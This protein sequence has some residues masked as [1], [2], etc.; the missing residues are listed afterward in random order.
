MPGI[1]FRCPASVFQVITSDHPKGRS[2][3]LRKMP[4]FKSVTAGPLTEATIAAM[5]S[6]PLD[7]VILGQGLAGTALAW[8]AHWAGLRFVV[9]DR[10][11]TVTSSKIAAGLMTPITGQRLRKSWRWSELWP[12]A[13]EYYRR[14]EKLTDRRFLRVTSMVRTLANLDEKKLFLERMREDDTR[15]HVRQP[16]HPELDPAVFEQTF[17]SFEMYDGGQ[18]NSAEYLT[19]S[20]EYFDRHDSVLT[21]DVDLECD[22]EL[23]KSGV[24]LPRWNLRAKRVVFCQGYAGFDNPWF[25]SVRFFAAKGE[26]LTV[27][28][29]GFTENRVIHGGL[30]LAPLGNERFRVGATYDWSRFD[31]VP[32][33]DGRNEIETRLRA[34]LRVPYTVEEHHAAVRPILSEPIPRLGFHPRWPQLGYFNG[35]ASKGALFAPYLS[36][37][38]V[39][40]ICGEEDVDWML[41]VARRMGLPP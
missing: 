27:H 8:R 39:R 25:G 34:W 4:D 24:E 26:M 35:L 19:A 5:N 32:T 11:E 10:D 41:D 12:V 21:A 1:W 36:P 17:G 2:P 13:V 29:P 14:V 15:D 7:L 37:H 23:T 40:V 22:L 38:L 16:P 30:W 33:H 31:N 3:A 20:R 6:P 9:I 18:L 28:I